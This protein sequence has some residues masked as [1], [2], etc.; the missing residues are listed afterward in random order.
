MTSG[1]PVV[2][3][4]RNPSFLDINGLVLLGKS[5][6]ETIDFPIKKWGFPVIFPLNQS[7]D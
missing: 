4:Q 6:P 5:Q 3:Q 2:G 7:I 1:Y